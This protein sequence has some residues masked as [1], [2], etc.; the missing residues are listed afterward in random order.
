MGCAESLSIRQRLW[1][2][3]GGYTLYTIQIHKGGHAKQARIFN[4]LNERIE[5]DGRFSAKLRCETDRKGFPVIY[6]KTVRLTKAKPYCGQ[7]PGECVVPFGGSQK[8][9]MSKL[10]EWDDWVKFHTLVNKALNRLKTDADVWTNPRDIRGK[11]WIRKGLCARV[12][13]SWEARWDYG[14]RIEVWNPGTDDQFAPAIGQRKT[15]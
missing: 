1:L 6:I 15:S 11:M 4:Y 12:K 9:P 10:L 2:L 5:K 13:W 3:T 8:K 7:H 14:H